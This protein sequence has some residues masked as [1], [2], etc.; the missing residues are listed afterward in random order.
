MD[1]PSCTQINNGAELGWLSKRLIRL[2]E[3]YYHLMSM[4]ELVMVLR[5]NPEVAVQRKTDENARDVFVRSTEV[6]EIDWQDTQVQVI[7]ASLS[8]S[9]V[10]SSIQSLVWSK[11]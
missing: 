2:E 5:V 9:E 7:D 4:P 6:W 1:G 11:L 8:E 10:L 3:K